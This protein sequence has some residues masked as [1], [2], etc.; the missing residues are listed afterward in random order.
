MEMQIL[1]Q[2]NCRDSECMLG[3]TSRDPKACANYSSYRNELNPFFITMTAAEGPRQWSLAH[4]P[5]TVNEYLVCLRFSNTLIS[6][7]YSECRD[8]SVVYTSAQSHVIILISDNRG[9]SPAKRCCFLAIVL[10]VLNRSSK[11]IIEIKNV[12]TLSRELIS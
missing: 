7:R 2:L 11:W 1:P 4:R 6:L 10:N 9:L 8:G 3:W 12:W 5:T